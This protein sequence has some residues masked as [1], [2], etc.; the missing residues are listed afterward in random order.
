MASSRRTWISVLLAAVIIAGVLAVA[1]VGGT[2]FFIYRHVNAE[3][4]NEHTADQEFDRA[5]A[6]FEGQTPLIEIRQG[7][8]PLVHRE[9][10]PAAAIGAR[11][12]NLRVLAYDERAGKL[13]RVS[14]PFWLL[15]ILPT[16]NLSF[17]NDQGIDVDVDSER[18]RLTV[19][20]LER[21]GPGL[22]LAQRD[23]HG[24]QVL[25]WTE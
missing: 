22:L 3:F 18:V 7:D 24:S 4:T 11:L 2:A 8:E 19:E 10:I 9:Q 17:L 14:I 20:D 15:R 6:R 23:R 13:V 25:V 16:K 21:R 12:E 1:V 5:R